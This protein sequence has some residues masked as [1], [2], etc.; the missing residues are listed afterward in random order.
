MINRYVIY[1]CYEYY[2][3]NGKCVTSW[4]RIGKMYNTKKDAEEGLKVIKE[5]TINT[6]KVSKLKQFFDIRYEDITKYPIPDL[7]TKNSPTIT[8]IHDKPILIFIILKMLP[9]LEGNTSLKS[10]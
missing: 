10:I 7:E 5:S 8:P 6:D 2:G 9:T 1:S 3:L 4:F